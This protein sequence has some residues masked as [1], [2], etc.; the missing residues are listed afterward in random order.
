MFADLRN[1]IYHG[2]K[3]DQQVH[4]GFDLSDVQNS[5]VEAAN[6]GRGGVGQE[7]RHLRQAASYWTTA[8]VCNRST[9]ICASSTSKKARWSKR[10]RRWG[11]PARP[12][13]AG[14]VHVHVSRQIDGVQVNPREWWDEHWIHDRIMSKL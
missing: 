11:S 10:D 14:G 6:D 4:L 1:Y 9:A 13:L 5:P 2:K 3:V 8:M 12:G 7:S